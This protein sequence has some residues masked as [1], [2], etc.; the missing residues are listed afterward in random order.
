MA[1]RLDSARSTPALTLLTQTWDSTV[2]RFLYGGSS[3]PDGLECWF[4][5]Y[6]GKGLGA[7]D[8]DAMPEPFL[9]PLDARPKMGFLAL[10]PG[11]AFCFQRRDGSFADRVRELGSYTSWAAPGRT[12][13]ATGSVRGSVQTATTR[14]G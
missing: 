4:H 11:R 7:V 14:P 1:D 12:S 5:A 2:D 9:G 3:V 8:P 13:K 10:N 6:A